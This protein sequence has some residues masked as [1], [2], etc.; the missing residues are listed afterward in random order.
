MSDG[1][2]FCLRQVN[3]DGAK[4]EAKSA[5]PFAEDAQGATGGRG[6]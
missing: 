1:A 4:S 6:S 2:I 3:Q 5:A